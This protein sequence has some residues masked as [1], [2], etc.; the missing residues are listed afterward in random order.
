MSK[1]LG[2]IYTPEGYARILTTWAIRSSTD[3]VLDLGVG[4]GIFVYQ[5]YKRLRDLGASGSKAVNQIYGS[6]IDKAVFEQFTRE[7][8]R[9]GLRFGNLQNIDFFN[10]SFPLVDAI[11]GNPPYVRRRGMLLENLKLIRNKTLKNNSKLIE[12][13]LS[14]LSDL[15]IYFLLYA[16]PLLKP[17]GRLATI[18][19]DSWLNTRYG[20]SLRKY[21]LDEFEIKQVVSLDRSVFENAQV[22]AVLI[23]A[24]KKKDA[25]KRYY[26]KFARVRNGLPINQL[27]SFILNGK[28]QSAENIVAKKIESEE[29]NAK[30]AWGAI[31]KT[32]S[33]FD[34]ISRKYIVKPIREIGSMQIGLETLAKGFFVISKQD[35]EDNVVEEKYL[36]P[37]AYSVYDFEEAVIIEN[38][39]PK[40]YVF[41]CSNSKRDLENTKAF[42]YIS[43]GEQKEVVIRGTGRT[44]VGYHNKDRIQKARRPNWYD[45]KTEC[46]KKAIAEILLP[47]FIYKEYRVLWNQACYIPGGAIIQFFPKEDLFTHFI[48]KR[49][50][51]ALLT[52]SLTEIAFRI[53]AQVYGGG[54]SNLSTA[55]INESPIIDVSQLSREHQ[56]HLID[57]YDAYLINNDKT[58]INQI[59]YEI[60]ELT[61]EEISGVDNLLLDLR[62]ISESAKKAA[63]P[64]E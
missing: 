43:Q 56:T 1:E 31:F 44:V 46:E 50:Y 62:K 21:L 7:A 38:D 61:K 57:A 17:G 37:F 23:L 13:D 19:A 6:E 33:L 10:T 32:T 3:T 2:A 58:Q 4:P 59:V 42:Q 16:F 48:D 20:F 54:T 40:E 49:V 63:H 39:D 28:N 27:S 11:I 22:K 51:L 52:S 5:A 15:Y 12:T 18:L 26:V 8:E 34:K 45:V 53:N 14:H 30:S 25:I 35:K 24:T 36:K 9:Q 41:Y 64:V 60:L 47:R 29:L 55:A